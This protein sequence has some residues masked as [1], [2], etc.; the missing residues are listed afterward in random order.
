MTQQTK[1]ILLSLFLLL[2]LSTQAQKAIGPL[3][4]KPEQS[5]APKTATDSVALPKADSAKTVNLKDSLKAKKSKKALDATVQYQAT[6]SVVFMGTNYAKMYGDSKVNYKEIELKADYIQMNM[7]S[8]IVYAQGRKDTAGKMVGEP[9]FKEKSNEY[10]SKTMR[11]NFKTKKGYITSVVTQQGE[12]YVVG[13][14][15]KKTEGDD[16][17]MTDCKYTTCDEHDHPHFYFQLTKAKV[18][19]K[20][21][22]VTGPAYLVLEDVPLP[23]AIPFGFF[24]F[25][26]KYS[27]GIL[28]PSYG[29]EL[30]RG[31]YLK[32]GGYYFA[33]NDYA[34]MAV[35]GEIYTKGS[36][37][38]SSTS[39]YTKKYK[40]SGNFNASYRMTVTGE[41]GQ[42]DYNKS[43]DFS[44]TWS[45][46]QDAKANPNMTFSASVNFA[47]S[48]Y[49]R[50]DLSSYYN[51]QAFTQNNKS[52]SVNLSWRNPRFPLTFNTS[53]NINQRSS[54]S[55]IS[56]SLPN[57]SIATSN[58]IYPFKRKEMIGKERWYE[59]IGLTYSGQLANSIDTKEDKLFNSNL[60]KDWRNGMQHS[61]PVSAT[62]NLLKY[63]NVTPSFN[64]RE[65]WFTN[66]IM[67]S[68]DEM[69][70][71]ELQDTIW[72]FNRMYNYSTS[73]SASTKLYGFYTPMPFLFGRKIQVIRHVFTPSLSFNYSP[74]FQ[75]NRSFWTSYYNSQTKANVYYSPYQGGLYYSA[76]GT[77]NGSVSFN[78]TNN[79][80]MKVRSNRD[81][82][83]VKKISLIDNFTTG[84]SYNLAADS[85]NWSDV[86][87]SIRMKL[88]KGFSLNLSGAFDTY[89]YKLDKNGNPVKV[90]VTR[91][92]KYHSFGLGRLMSTGTSFSYTLN[93]ETFNKLFGG[94]EEGK[95]KDGK[96]DKKPETQPDQNPESDNLAGDRDPNK[97]KEEKPTASF[98][99]DGYMLWSVPW[100][101]SFNYS[102]RYGYSTFNKEK[103]E[104]NHK[105]T[106]NLGFSGN[107]TLTPGWVFN[108]SSSYDFDTHKISYTNINFSRDLHCWQ[109]T[110]GVVPFGAYRS[111]NVT[112]SVK[113]SLLKDVKYDKRGNSY[114]AIPWY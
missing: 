60:I 34:D 77:T 84:I 90:N 25:T 63:I 9:I 69:N 31:F 11:Y 56:V 93:N 80:E 24:P 51:A 46:S 33:I 99:K 91:W 74:D 110:A 88:T 81:S 103:L 109:A 45:H 95:D 68:W 1:Y 17:F 43:K 32:D 94:K 57:L 78:M 67:R 98:D 14:K 13:G 18:R 29:E 54:D 15:T 83:G 70:N 86:N 102:M 39:T 104:Y 44:L 38:L 113:S 23:L 30:T 49:A 79:L 96:K 5:A 55:S 2:L 7:D 62:F 4:Q 27:S 82:S 41:K 42:S 105:I 20:R 59:K 111:F 85:M 100:S 108:M 53:M 71:K 47:T 28:M 87:A 8:S 48:S 37:G 112:I 21:N 101:L 6:D 106:H 97:K 72:G 40:F 61:I 66:R 73:V 75:N 3:S 114:D 92:E 64:Y 19:P 26:E 22:V 12:G 16:L 58:R 10:N 107:I 35:R 65:S 36:W 76:P 50:H 52:S 89:T